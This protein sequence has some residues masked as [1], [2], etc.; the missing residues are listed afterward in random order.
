MLAGTSREGQNNEPNDDMD[1]HKGRSRRTDHEAD[2]D[3]GQGI[4]DPGHRKPTPTSRIQTRTLDTPCQEDEGTLTKIFLLDGKHIWPNLDK[5]MDNGQ[6]KQ[7][8]QQ[9]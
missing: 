1:T 3:N 2:K 9:R 8:I 4:D 7:M 6:I 5:H